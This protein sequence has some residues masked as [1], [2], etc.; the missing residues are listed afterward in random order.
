MSREQAESV[1]NPCSNR[2]S[3]KNFKPH[4]RLALSNCFL[5]DVFQLASGYRA[6]DLINHLPALEHD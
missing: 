4:T 6:H 2:Q 3:Q 1:A 5:N